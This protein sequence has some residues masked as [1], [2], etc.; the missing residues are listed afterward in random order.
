MRPCKTPGIDGGDER[1]YIAVDA[2]GSDSACPNW[3][4]VNDDLA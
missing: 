4:V 2:S 1:G 3:K